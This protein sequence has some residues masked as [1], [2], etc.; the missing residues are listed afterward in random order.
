MPRRNSRDPESDPAAAFGEALG[1]LREAAGFATQESAAARLNYGHDSISRWETGAVVP[2]ERQVNRLLDGYGVTGVTRE[3]TL[4]MWRL[5][6]KAKGPIREFFQKYFAEEQEAAFLRVWGLLMI[7]G[8]LQTQNY[9]YAMFLAEGLDEG[10]AAEQ[11]ELR[12]K[13]RA[14]VDGSDPAHVTALVHERALYF[15]VGT[16]ETMT[17]QLTDL[18]ELSRRRNV[19]IQVIPDEGY[20][21]GAVGPFEIASGLSTSDIVDM[22]TVEDYVTDEPTVISKVIARFQQIHGYARSATESRTFMTEA[23]QWWESQQK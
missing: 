3:N 17:E 5:A 7:P 11:T 16:P 8:P 4:T 10:E 23:L 18:L 6:R 1:R 21:Q 9:A 20:F 2:D 12:M 15:R 19:V 22:V 13:R 14:R